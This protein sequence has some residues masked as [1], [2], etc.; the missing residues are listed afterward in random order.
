ML[1][2]FDIAIIGGGP[3]GSVTGLCL[4]RL[5]WR[6]AILEASAFEGE[7]PGETLPPEINPVL[8]ELGLVE[9]FH[10]CAPIE[11]PGVVSS[12]AS[13]KAQETDFTFNPFGFGWHIDRRRFD[14]ML[15]HAAKQ[16]GASVFMRKRAEIARAGIGWEVR[17][18]G[19]PTLVARFVVDATGRNGCRMDGSRE[20]H[21]E[22]ALLA[23]VLRV[24]FMDMQ[25]HDQ[26]TFIEAAPDGWW[27]SACV[28][29][30]GLI[31]MFFTD[32]ES[33]R[34]GDAFIAEQMEHA[35]SVRHRMRGEIA[36]ITTSIVAVSSSSRHR[37][38]GS[39]WLAAGDSACSFDPLSGRGIFKAL[40]H[41][42]AAARAADGF[43]RGNPAALDEYAERVRREFDSYLV[44]KKLF[45]ASQTRWRDRPFWKA[46][47]GVARASAA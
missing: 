10:E 32:R 25:A 3:A 2:E 43:L 8:R 41:G 45:Y 1:Q 14:M 33:F 21:T 12:W 13:G 24:S 5:G 23:T 20:R 30:N 11:S 37:I 40:Q 35:P 6:V 18:R 28:P 7:R 38:T 15:F 9:S 16:A 46:R 44:Q 29:V 39:G 36:Q 27:Y 19:E 42:I 34:R 26:R 31:A 4:A 47:A 17:R 22:D